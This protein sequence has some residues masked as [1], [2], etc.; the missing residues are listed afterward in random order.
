MGR[1]YVNFQYRLSTFMLF[2]ASVTRLLDQ[3]S[4]IDQNKSENN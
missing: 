2:P 3:P 1:M 4:Y